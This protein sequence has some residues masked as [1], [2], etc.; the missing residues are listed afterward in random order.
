MPTKNEI[1]DL[2]WSEPIKIGHWVGF[3][4]LTDLH[5]EWLRTFLFA[6]NDETLQAHRGSYKTTVLSLFFAIHAIIKPNEPLIY[7]RK[8]NSDVV[9][10]IRQVRNIL[11][12]PAV[13]EIVKIL[14]GQELVIIKDTGNEITTNLPTNIKG[15]SQILGLGVGSSITGKHADIVVTDDIIN[16]KDRASEAERE[17]TKL[18]YQELQNIKNRGGRLVNTG[19]PWHIDDAFSLMSNIKKYD[20]YSTGLM[21]QAQIYELKQRMS[22]SLF[23]ANYELKHIA[24]DDLLFSAPDTGGTA[25]DIAGGLAHLDSAFYGSDYTAFTIMQKHDGKFYLLGKMWRKSVDECYSDIV[26]MCQHHAVKRLHT[27]RNADKGMVAKQLKQLGVNV[28]AYDE[29][30]NKHVKIV[31]YLKAIWQDVVIVDGTDDAYI[32]QI[33]DYNE[34]A[35]HDDAPDSAACL[36]RI[37]IDNMDKIGTLDKRL[38]GF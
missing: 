33:C 6:D 11:R 30:T 32:K 25:L 36:A 27:E 37:Y 34:N 17:K 22:A 18:A 5:N 7:Q 4:D 2:I 23:A 28:R 3:N 19:T 16:N 29:S 35:E 8:S 13:M 38:L 31:T 21:T 26:N 12:S 15:A 1:L 14:Y 10:I 24:D 20:C 9:E